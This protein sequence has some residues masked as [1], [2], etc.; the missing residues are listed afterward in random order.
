MRALFGRAPS[1]S[2]AKKP[3]SAVVQSGG[4][5][6]GLQDQ[7]AEATRPQTVCDAQLLVSH[8]L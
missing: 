3:D 1:S 6:G 7:S 5:E 8:A 4:P 2:M